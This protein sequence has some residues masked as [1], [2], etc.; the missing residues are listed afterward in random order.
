MPI[1]PRRALP[2]PLASLLLLLALASASS[3]FAPAVLCAQQSAPSAVAASAAA[4]F[5]VAQVRSYPFPNEL[6]AAAT[7]SRIAW[8]LNERGLRNVWVAE[9]P[10]FVARQ[11]TRYD[12]DDGQ[13]LTSVQLSADGRWVVYVRGGDHGGTWEDAAPVNPTQAAP[14]PPKV[15]VWTVPF[16]GGEPKSLGEG[17]E[18]AISPKGDVVAFVKDRQ[19]WSAPIDGSA[20][21]TRLVGYRGDAGDLEWSPDGSRLAFVANRG[22]HAFVAVYAGDSTALVLLAPST[23][24]DGSPRWSPDGRRIA[25]V[26]RPGSGGAPDSVLARRP[27]PWAIWTADARTGEAHSLW[28]SPATLRG[29][30]PNNSFPLC[31]R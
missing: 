30:T 5:S 28:T 26:R 6:A 14:A 13:E 15:Q 4:P 18:P 29:S 9:G 31:A 25:F 19:I 16:G 12:R 20:P 24:R 11:L 17:D 23:S 10:A 22:D 27:E 1:A 7:G 2:H 8:A 3:P 21:A